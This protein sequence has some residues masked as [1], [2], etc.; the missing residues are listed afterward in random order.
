MLVIYKQTVYLMLYHIIATVPSDF[1][2]KIKQIKS[3]AAVLDVAHIR[4][5]RFSLGAVCHVRAQGNWQARGQRVLRGPFIFNT[6]LDWCVSGRPVHSP[7]A[8]RRR[9]VHDAMS[10]QHG[11]TTGQDVQPV[12]HP[13][14][15]HLSHSWS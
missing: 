1:Y 4:V 13:R 15:D 12:Y 10:A 9:Y 8:V 3:V 2:D 6:F 7:M 11:V 14:F 5:P